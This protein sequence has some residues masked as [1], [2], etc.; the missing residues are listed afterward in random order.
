MHSGSRALT[1]A[2]LGVAG[3]IRV[4]LGSLGSDYGL[5]G[6][7]RFAWVHWG[8]PRGRQV[9]SSSRRFLGFLK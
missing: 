1:R 5:A 4:S 7:F 6:S 3:F 8:D 2:D 9:H